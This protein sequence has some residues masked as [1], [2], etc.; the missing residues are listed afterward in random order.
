MSTPLDYASPQ[1]R[2]ARR[3]YWAHVEVLACV[4]LCLIVFQTCVRIEEM[5]WSAGGYLPRPAS[6]GGKWRESRV[7]DETAFRFFNVGADPTLMS[8]PLSPAERRTIGQNVAANRL[9]AVVATW[10]LAQY[11]L[12]PPAVV[13]ALRL[14]MLHGRGLRVRAVAAVC[15]VASLAAGASALYRGYLTALGW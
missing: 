9:R 10:G 6:D 5:N 4:G 7:T 12:V 8:R 14:L 15:L 13:L 1:A 3:R 11:V 2:P